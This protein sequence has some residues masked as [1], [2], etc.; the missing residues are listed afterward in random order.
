MCTRSLCLLLTLLLLL[1]G[2]GSG[3]RNPPARGGSLL[4]GLSGTMAGTGG[5][6]WY[7]AIQLDDLTEADVAALYE[8]LGVAP[9]AEP[10]DAGSEADPT[11]TIVQ[12]KA[13]PVADTNND[14]FVSLDE[15]V[16]MFRTGYTQREI[17]D[18]LQQ[19]RNQYLIINERDADML[20]EEGVPAEIVE[21]MQRI[22]QQQR[23]ALIE[24][25]TRAAVD[26]PLP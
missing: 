8:A 21:R 9:P 10:A 4:G 23:A 5:A 7:R 18:A 26:G 11:A 14:G 15:V 25:G 12:A 1:P 20:I 13:P 3:D 17:I 22:D 2:C 24:A 19:A 6:Y 16:G